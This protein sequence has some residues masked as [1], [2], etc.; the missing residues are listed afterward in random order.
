MMAVDNSLKRCSVANMTGGKAVIQSLM[1]QGV[2]TAFGVISIHMMAV[3]DALYDVQDKFRFI[4]AR[5]E[6]AAVYEADGY[7]RA[8]GKP[9]VCFTSTGPGAANTLGAMGE[10]WSASSP[11]LQVTSNIDLDLINK[12]LG[13]LHEPHNQ[14]QMFESVTRWTAQPHTHQ[15]ISQTMLDAFTR[16]RTERPGPIEIEVPTDILH[17]SAD[18]EVLGERAEPRT[19]GDPTAVEQAAELLAKGNR[20]AIWAGGGVISSAA[21]AELQTLAESLGAVVVTT[22]GGKGAFPAD[23]PLYAGVTWGGRGPYGQNPIQGYLSTCDAVLVVGSRMPYHMTKLVALEL[24]ENLVQIDLDDQELGKNYPAKVGIHGDA[25]AVLGQLS[26]ALAAK[27][28]ERGHAL[29]QEAAGLR[30]QVRDTFAKNEANQQRTLDALRRIIPREAV[31]VCDATLAAYSAVQAF[32][33]YEPHTYIGPHG[34]ADIGFGFPA[35]LGAAVGRPDVPV[36]LMSG[37]GGFQLNLQEL[38]TAAQ[39]NIPIVAIIWNNNA[40]G[41]LKGTQKSAFGGRFMASE[42]VNPDFVRLADS[43]GLAA[44]RVA[45][46]AELE[47]TLAAA[48]SKKE[49]RLIEVSLPNELAGFV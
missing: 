20:I 49:F 37:D 14:Q 19:A 1:A 31:V 27:N 12:G 18:V 22:Y 48:L 35:A 40:W 10:A 47:K 29:A 13:S 23:H 44:T 9:G 26:E 17:S 11:V 2:D 42:L 36:V 43:Y 45:T 16:F 32:P 4:S 28:V 3:Y 39:Y 24:P 41:V 30:Q 8:T 38:G 46:L 7:A 6:Q 33:V 21:S 25:K 34:W 15:E 5:H